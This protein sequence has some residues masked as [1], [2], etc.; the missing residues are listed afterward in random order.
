MITAIY[1]EVNERLARTA[2]YMNSFDDYV[3]GSVTSTQ[4]NL[5]NQLVG[6][7]NDLLEKYPNTDTATIET[8]QYYCDKYSKKIAFA[9]D[10]ENSIETMCPSV[11]ISGAGNFPTQRKEKQ[12]NARENFWKE[13]GDLFAVD[14]KNYYFNKIENAITNSTIYSNDDKVIEKLENKLALTN[15]RATKDRIE[16]IKKL[17]ERAEKPSEEKYIKVGGVE[18]IENAEAMRI[19]LKFDGKPS[20]EIRTLLKSNGFKWTPSCG[21]WQRQLTNNGIYSTKQ[22]L[23]KLSDFSL[24]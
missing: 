12:N 5:V 19:Q 2:K 6:Y 7:A 14:Y 11:L 21:V 8:V 15:D 22:L 23:K 20:E 1:T 24:V 18:V 9:I 17:K 13:Y 4:N 10:K 16:S 3:E